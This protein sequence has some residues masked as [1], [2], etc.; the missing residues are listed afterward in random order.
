M[1]VDLAAH[2]TLV[3][4]RLQRLA[5]DLDHDPGALAVFWA[6]VETNAAPLVEPVPDAP[7]V[8]WVTFVWRE[9]EPVANVV[10]I[11]SVTGLDFADRQLR[12]LPGTDLWYRTVRMR[13]TVRTSYQFAPNDSL[14][15]K[16]EETDWET[17]RRTWVPDPLNPLRVIDPAPGEEPGDGSHGGDSVLSLPNAAP[18]PWISRRKGIPRGIVTVHRFESPSLQNE[19]DLWV[20]T[21]AGYDPNGDPL[22]VLVLFD[23]QWHAGLMR[24]PTVLDNLIAAGAVPPL[25]A[26]MIGNVDRGHELPCNER[27]ASAVV[28]EMLPWLAG[29][30]RVT[31]DPAQRVVAGQSYGGL[32]AAW[33]GLTHP[34][35]FPN[36]L[37]QSGSYW[38][39]PDAQQALERAELGDAAGWGWLPARTAAEPA[40]PVRFWMEVGTL[41][42]RSFRDGMPGMVWV[43]RH[44]RDVLRAKGYVVT[45][46]E[47][48]GGHDFVWW[49]SGL[50]DGLIALL[51]ATSPAPERQP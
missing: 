27:F 23:G 29:R 2:P 13:D 18:E 21:P 41:E 32:A 51:G 47:Y 7:G 49:R 28:N 24:V 6:E 9:T 43:N 14:V 39:Q 44:M 5:A 15:P 45:Y 8:V 31:S 25:I 36:V 4:P 1:V 37:S 3:S 10:L 19:R 12:K 42:N 16:G 20:Y 33:C 50:A 26:L 30:Y 46:R 34:E 40:V 11:E 38:W 17:R 22:P 48:A 35:T